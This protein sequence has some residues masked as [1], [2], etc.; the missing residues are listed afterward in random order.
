M[1][2]DLFRYLASA[3]FGV[4]WVVL[5]D[6]D[7]LRN[8]RMIRWEGGL[9]IAYRLSFKLRRVG[10]LDNG[11][12]RNGSY[13]HGWEPYAPLASKKWPKFDKAAAQ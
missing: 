1:A 5:I 4:R 10:L 9:P 7:G 6:F 2:A 11:R 8:I 12:V 13:V 3:I